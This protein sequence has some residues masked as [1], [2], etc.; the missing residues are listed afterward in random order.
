VKPSPVHPAASG[1]DTPC[2]AAQRQVAKC[3]SRQGP[4]AVGSGLPRRPIA[5]ALK[6]GQ[7][8]DG[9]P[10]DPQA[11]DLQRIGRRG[12]LSRHKS[13]KRTWNARE[14]QESHPGRFPSLLSGPRRVH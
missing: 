3:Q 11:Q 7:Q 2:Q 4:A 12:S 6:L 10:S 9:T 8:S 5:R 14:S 13:R 1:L